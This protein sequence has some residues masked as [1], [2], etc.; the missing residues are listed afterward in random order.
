MQNNQN[1]SL[2]KHLSAE[3]ERQRQKTIKAEVRQFEEEFYAEL[4]QLGFRINNATQFHPFLFQYDVRIIP[5]FEKYL[6]RA[7]T[8]TA[9]THI[10]SFSNFMK[11]ML[12]CLAHKN[13][14]AATAF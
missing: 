9:Y 4:R 10:G 7:E 8:V 2:S 11:L 6:E 5:I 13:M 14:K 1:D 12:D 3:E